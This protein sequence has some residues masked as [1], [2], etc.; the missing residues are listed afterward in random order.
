MCAI[1][2]SATCIFVLMLKVVSKLP[3]LVDQIL[4]LLLEKVFIVCNNATIAI[5]KLS[6]NSHVNTII[7]TICKYRYHTNISSMFICMQYYFAIATICRHHLMFEIDPVGIL[8]NF[9]T[10]RV[11]LFPLDRNFR[12]TFFRIK[13]FNCYGWLCIGSQLYLKGVDLVTNGNQ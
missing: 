7:W 2:Y 13:D 6:W 11:E 10:G 5:V 3:Q 1:H 8:I 4:I 9:K 12:N